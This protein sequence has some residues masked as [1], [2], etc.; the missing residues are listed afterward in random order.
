MATALF[1][2]MDEFIAEKEDWEQ[3]TLRLE[4]FFKVNRVQDAEEKKALLFTVIGPVAL[5]LLRSLIAPDRVENKTF[6]E[7]M[8]AMKVHCCPKPSEVVQT[9][10]FN[11]KVRQPGESVSTYVSQLRTLAE[12]CNFGEMLERMLRD[13][14]VCGINDPRIQRRLLAIKDLTFEVALQ[15]ALGLEAADSNMQT[16]ETL[17]S[18]SA[19]V[20]KLDK[21]THHATTPPQPS[22]GAECF[23][24]GRKG[25]A[26]AKCRL[27][28]SKCQTHW[29]YL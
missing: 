13:R 26:P 27:K 19:A 16:L 9:F 10:K 15:E 11:T 28:S 24:C 14:L 5:R 4:S 22:S 25:H 20:H 18:D 6:K 29:A 7:L 23:R 8:T 17:T 1:G 12:H 2:R 21:G 3:Y